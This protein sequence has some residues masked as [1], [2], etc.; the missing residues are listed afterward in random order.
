MMRNTKINQSDLS[1]NQ[2][3]FWLKPLESI[4]N[5]PRPKHIG[6]RRRQEILLGENWN[7]NRLFLNRPLVSSVKFHAQIKKR[8]KKKLPEEDFTVCNPQIQ[9]NTSSASTWFTLSDRAKRREY[10]GHKIYKRQKGG[11][12]EIGISKQALKSQ[13]TGK[14]RYF[15]L[16]N[17]SDLPCLNKISQLDSQFI[18]D[19]EMDDDWETDQ[20]VLE[21]GE[22]YNRRKLL[23]T[24]CI[25]LQ[26]N[27]K[28]AE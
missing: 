2:K 4:Q 25:V 6:K 17:E 1:V 7:P 19:N 15:S 5:Q 20:E 3:N 28:P 26:K 8:D 12:Q 11:K 13:R 16:Y 27:D 23:E 18:M 21:N 9:N 14:W 22:N 24:L 10:Q